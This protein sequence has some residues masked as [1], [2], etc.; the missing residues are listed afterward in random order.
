MNLVPGLFRCEKPRPKTLATLYC[1]AEIQLDGADHYFRQGI[2]IFVA[3]GTAGLA[4][5]C[6]NK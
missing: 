3:I 1:K 6:S 4:A 2:A 5:I